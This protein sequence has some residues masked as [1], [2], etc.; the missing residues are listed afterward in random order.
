MAKL[1]RWW[2]EHWAEIIIIGGTAL[3]IYL[4]LLGLGII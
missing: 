1:K 3:S 2:K 4:L